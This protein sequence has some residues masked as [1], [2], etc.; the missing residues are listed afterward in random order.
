MLRNQFAIQAKLHEAMFGDVWLCRDLF[1]ESRLVAIKQVHLSL[2]RQAFECYQ[3][4][5]NPWTERRTLEILLQIGPHDNVLQIFQHFQQN[6]TWFY[7][8]EFCSGGDLHHMLEQT[9]DHRL[10]ENEAMLLFKQVARG[11]QWLHSNGIAHRDLSLE[12][13]LLDRELRIAKI[14]DFGLS[15]KADRICNERVGKAYYMAPEVVART[16]YDPRA[17]DVWSLGIM[18]FVLLTGSPLVP[19]ASDNEAG[20]IGLMEF[21]VGRILD[22]WHMGGLVSPATVE[23][24]V[25]MLKVD[26]ATRFSIDNV[27]AH[28]AFHAT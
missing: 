21:G 20:F 5:D 27:V 1:N 4:L 7:V 10:P 23:L 17:A 26:P 22:M 19:I 3:E 11:V 6:D 16:A 24:L 13:V 2:A 25:G 12:N 18:L 8:M 15:T 28:A 9:A 14:C